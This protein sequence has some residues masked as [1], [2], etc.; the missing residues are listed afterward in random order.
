MKV[1][2]DSGITPPMKNT[3]AVKTYG[4]QPV[5]V[6]YVNNLDEDPGQTLRDSEHFKYLSNLYGEAYPHWKVVEAPGLRLKVEN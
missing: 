6:V 1:F 3:V 4:N 2:G 5:I